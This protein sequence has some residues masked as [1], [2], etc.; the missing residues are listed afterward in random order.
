MHQST[1]RHPT[2]A[3]KETNENIPQKNVLKTL[4]AKGAIIW[5]VTTSYTLYST[6]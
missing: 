3:F 4:L 5:L 2:A 1:L 6:R